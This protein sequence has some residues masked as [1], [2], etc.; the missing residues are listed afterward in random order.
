[1]YIY[2][3][4]LGDAA[5]RVHPLAGQGLNLG[6][7]DVEV[8]SKHFHNHLSRGENLFADYSKNV[9]KKC[10]YDFESERQLKLIPMMGAIHSMQELF[11][12]VP[13]SALSAFN[14]MNF[15]KQQIVSFA[16]SN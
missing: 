13:S 15:I 3:F 4:F 12:L 16:N 11:N 2:Y 1:M 6:I 14:Q 10:L 5:H 8:L 7:G 9:L